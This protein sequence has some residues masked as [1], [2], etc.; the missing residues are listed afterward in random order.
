MIELLLQNG[1]DAR[2]VSVD[3]WSPL[4]NA[5]QFSRPNAIKMLLEAGAD[6]NIVHVTKRTPLFLAALNCT[7]SSARVCVVWRSVA[8]HW[9][10]HDR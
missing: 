4:H 5:A 8:W 3:G 2:I 7:W 10:V 9:R 1:A 6:P